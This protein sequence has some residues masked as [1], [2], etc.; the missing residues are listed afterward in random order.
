MCNVSRFLWQYGGIL[1]KKFSKAKRDYA[2]K[3]AFVSNEAG[4]PRITFETK[5]KD[6]A[7]FVEN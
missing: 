7:R 3:F 5:Q 6:S 1:R 2:N 4:T